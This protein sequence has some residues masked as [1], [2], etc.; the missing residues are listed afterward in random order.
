MPRDSPEDYGGLQMRL[1]C[2]CGAEITPLDMEE[3]RMAQQLPCDK[4]SNGLCN[5][6]IWRR[7]T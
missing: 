1:K 6:K 2:I 3:L 4:T 7:D 5:F